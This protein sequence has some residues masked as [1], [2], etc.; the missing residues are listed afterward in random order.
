QLPDEFFRAE[1]PFPL[2]PAGQ[3]AAGLVFLPGRTDGDPAARDRAKAEVERIAA[4]EHLTVLGW[5]GV[6]HDP[7]SCGEGARAV[8]P[9]LEQL[10]VAAAPVPGEDAAAG[11]AGLAGRRPSGHTRRA[12]F[13]RQRADAARR[14][15]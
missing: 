10:F 5:R 3:Y 14:G 2:P 15:Y 8:L 9:Y 7:A 13:L 4:A 6:P 11:P 1:C 12:V